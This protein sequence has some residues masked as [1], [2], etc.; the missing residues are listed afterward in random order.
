MSEKKK[1]SCGGCIGLVLVL[2][3]AVM[4]VMLV[5]KD[6]SSPTARPISTQIEQNSGR[7]PEVP[8][9]EVGNSGQLSLLPPHK[10][11]PSSQLG[12]GRSQLRAIVQRGSLTKREFMD[13]AVKLCRKYESRGRAF[14]LVQF[15]SDASCL[16]D[17]D[18]RGLLRESD[19]PH[20]LCDISVDP[21]GNGQLYAR[22]FKLAV[23]G[24]TGQE[25]TDVLAK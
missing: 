16:D 21:D 2:G 3:I 20:W 23:N 4:V 12:G 7:Q 13:V 11:N 18:G 25:R 14:F 17:W 24:T 1:S 19:W 9:E 22:T 5:S 8:S 6:G 15:F 10:F